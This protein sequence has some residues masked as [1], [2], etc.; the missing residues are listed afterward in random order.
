MS[1][2]QFDEIETHVGNLTTAVDALVALK[3]A[4]NLTADQQ[5]QIDTALDA[6]SQKAT[7]ASG[8]GTPPTP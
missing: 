8:G 7:D 2:S 3:S 5:A 6:V 1:T 4:S